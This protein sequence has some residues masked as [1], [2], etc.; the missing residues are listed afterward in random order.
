MF[1]HHTKIVIFG[2]F[3]LIFGSGVPIAA[4]DLLTGPS[5][6]VFKRPPAKGAPPKK[7]A[8]RKKGQ[9][10]RR[11]K[12]QGP[13]TATAATPASKDPR[14]PPAQAIHE[15]IGVTLWKLRPESAGESGARLLSMGTQEQTKLVAERVELDTMFVKGDKVRISVESPRAGYLYIVDRELKKDGSLGEPYL[16]YP[17]LT[18]GGGDN[19]VRAGKVIEIPAQTDNPFYYE[20]TPIE[21]N[22]AGEMLTILVSPTKIEGLTLG[23][24]PI[25]L[26]LAMVAEWEQKW[27][28][29]STTFELDGGT[30]QKY[31][32]EEKEAGTGT[33]QLT[34][35]S[36]SPQSVILVDAKKNSPF[37]VSF[38]LRVNTLE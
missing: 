25:K 27:E 14:I 20:I 10:P 21:E 33:R 13:E 8:Y 26:P 2:I 28:G 15:Q 23:N 6:F 11:S 7:Q 30:G 4:Q 24:S 1:R 19:R 16:I 31:T 35:K 32:P 12:D 22:Y 17:T 36:P 5:V 9:Q 38:P 18:T 29:S 3:S 37:M 34:H